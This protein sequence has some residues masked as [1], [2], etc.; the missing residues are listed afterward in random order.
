[1]NATHYQVFC[2]TLISFNW[3]EYCQNILFIFTDANVSLYESVFKDVVDLINCLVSE[4]F[5]RR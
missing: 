1:M 4:Y 3:L 2:C 5:R